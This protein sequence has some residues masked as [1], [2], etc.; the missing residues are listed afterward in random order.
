MYGEKE[1]KE[2]FFVCKSS[3]LW[4]IVGEVL[5]KVLL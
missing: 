4:K 3:I 5:M 1:N 2:T